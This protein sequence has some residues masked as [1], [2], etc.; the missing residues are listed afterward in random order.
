MAPA[1]RAGR[2][3]A[4]RGGAAAGGS[5]GSPGRW[6]WAA[7]AGSA[8][9]GGAEL[10][11][12]VSC[13]FL[14]IILVCFLV[15]PLCPPHPARRTPWSCHTFGPP[16]VDSGHIRASPKT[17]FSGSGAALLCPQTAPGA[18]PAVGSFR[19]PSTRV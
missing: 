13:I 15:P 6:R 14:A 2:S 7:G 16:L 8:G 10:C 19:D 18:G 3:G 1:T 5:R 11:A 12:L 4:G 9:G 17:R